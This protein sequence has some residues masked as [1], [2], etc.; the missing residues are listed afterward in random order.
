MAAP[1][2]FDA[3]LL[4]G[5]AALSDRV[6]G[7]VDRDAA[8]LEPMRAQVAEHAVTLARLRNTARRAENLRATMGDLI[9]DAPVGD[10]SA[11]LATL[12]QYMRDE[13][14]RR[15]GVIAQSRRDKK[16][17]VHALAA[18]RAVNAENQRLM[19]AE[20]AAMRAENAELRAR[21]A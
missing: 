5:F 12:W 18:D 21:L 9:G 8:L 10:L 6:S 19:L 20:I 11:D 15:P 7:F 14:A 13:Q 17:M 16:L 1:S 2:A 3:V 4:H